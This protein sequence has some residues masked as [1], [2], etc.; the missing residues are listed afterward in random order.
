[1]NNTSVQTLFTST[2]IASGVLLSITSMLLPT[3]SYAHG[4]MES[5]KARQ[6]ICQEQGGYWWPSDGSNMP[7]FACRAA[8]LESGY[9]AFVQEHEISVNVADYYNQQ[10]VM[11]AIPDGSLCSAGVFEKRGLNLASPDWQ[12]TK[13][14]PNGQ[15][16]IQIRFNAKTPHNP[17]FWKLYLSKPGFNASTDV[18]RWQDLE[19]IQE[20][21]NIDFIKTPDG[22]RYYDMEVTIPADRQGDALLYSRWQRDDVVGEGFYNC[23]DINIVRDDIAPEQWLPQDYFVKQGQ[24]ANAGDIVWLRLFNGSGQELINQH[25]EV[26]VANVQHWQA[27]FS[28]L[29]NTLHD[30]LIK[31]GIKT[32][33]GDIRFDVNNLLSNKV[34]TLDADYSFALSVM[35]QSENTAPIVHQL[36]PLNMDE[37]TAA[38]V[39]VHAFDDQNDPLTYQWQVAAPLSFTG[40]GADISLL[41]GEVERDQLVTVSVAVSDGKLTTSQSFNVN[42]I[43]HPGLPNIPLWLGT[44]AYSAG[45]KVTYQGKVYQAKW[46][47]KNQIPA[48]SDAWKLAMPDNGQ[49]PSWNNQTAYQGGTQV[50]HSGSKYSAKWWTQGDEPGVAS[51]WQKS[52]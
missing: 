37:N 52:E 12:K 34:W 49:T 45:N 14:T 38:S 48:T 21:G 31:I 7:N 41:A 50:M 51:V 24:V 28:T 13:V 39:H 9:I 22:S 8:F 44:E 5:P 27:D 10:A 18:L 33:E 47:N 3:T 42:I 17:S 16:N 20:Y 2:L 35:P 26:T 40:S 32:A 23:S 25:F 1:M 36:T 29:L 6:S 43:N 46:W 4:F 11:A 19:L 30:Q 15:G